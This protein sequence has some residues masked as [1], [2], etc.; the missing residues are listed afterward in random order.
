VFRH[1][2]DSKPGSKPTQNRHINS[3][4]YSPIDP[5]EGGWE[6]D[7]YERVPQQD[8]L[9]GVVV[10]GVDVGAGSTRSQRDRAR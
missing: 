4:V 5:Q 3:T 6:L 9:E 7:A 8:L 2:L 1:K 10:G